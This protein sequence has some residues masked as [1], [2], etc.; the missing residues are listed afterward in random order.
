MSSRTALLL[1]LSASVVACSG[2]AFE[3][4]P[5]GRPTSAPIAPVAP[6]VPTPVATAKAV[7]SPPEEADAGPEAS[8]PEQDA[9]AD[10]EPARFGV[11]FGDLA[12]E[13]AV[14]DLPVAYQAGGLAEATWE[15]WFKH[16]GFPA[17]APPNS[18]NGRLFDAGYNVGCHVVTPDPVATEA[19]KVHCDLF[20]QAS[21][22]SASKPSGWF[23]VALTFDRGVFRLY[24]D[25][26]EAGSASVTEAA[27]RAEAPEFGDFSCAGNLFFGATSRDPSSGT[28]TVDEFRIS[29]SA[30][31]AAAF[32]PPKHLSSAGADL[33]LML[34]D[35]QGSTSD[36]GKARLYAPWAAVS[37]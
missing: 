21:I 37:R 19:G 7:P 22:R 1:A 33:T 6:S 28:A 18:L 34:D 4:I 15:G 13:R 10:A 32:A 5:S 9:S 25:G 29:P 11:A 20:G 14:A 23:H 31:Y 26:Q 27:L 17:D 3:P 24:L 16:G 2:S 12:G 35:G 8:S 30:R 36:S